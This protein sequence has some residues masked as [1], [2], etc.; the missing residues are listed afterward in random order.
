MVIKHYQVPMAERKIER[1]KKVTG[2]KTVKEALTRAVE[3]CI[4]QMGR[5]PG[6][7]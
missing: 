6:T 3:Y 5:K 1:L 4:K 7:V 2:E